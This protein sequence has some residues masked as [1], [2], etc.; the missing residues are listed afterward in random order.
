VFTV[1]I[2]NVADGTILPFLPIWKGI[3]S[4]PK[5]QEPVWTP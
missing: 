3:N 4:L 5:S 2:G 1:C